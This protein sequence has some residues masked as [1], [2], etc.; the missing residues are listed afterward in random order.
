M[1]AKASFKGVFAIF[2]FVLLL[3]VASALTLSSPETLSQ[4][5]TSTTITATSN[6]AYNQTVSI[7]TPLRITD[8]TY[9]FD[10]SVVPTTFV[11]NGGSSGNTKDITL[12]TGTIPSSFKFGKWSTNL[13]A[14]GT[15][16]TGF[17][18]NNSVQVSFVKGFCSSGA[19]GTN[20][21]IRSVD[22]ENDGEGDE[23]SWNLLDQISVEVRVENNGEDRIRDVIVELGLFD[24]TGKNVIDD[25][26]F[27][28][29]DDEK[30][31]I[32]SLSDGDDEKVLFEFKVPADMETKDYRL[33]AKVYSDDI[34]QSKECDDSASSGLSDDYYETVSVETS[35]DQIIAF[36][37]ITFSP[38]EATCGDAV[39]V[40]FDVYNVGDDDEDQ[41]RVNLV[42]KELGIDLSQEIR[43]GLDAG[44]GKEL[45]FTFT[46]P[47][48]AANKNYN[49]KFDADY[50]YND[51]SD[52]YR[53]SM[54]NPE[55]FAYKVFGCSVNGGSS[56]SNT[57]RIASISA[58]L[59]SDAQAGK[60]LVIRSTIRNTGSSSA[61]FIAGASGYE[62]WAD[63][64]SINPRTFTIGAGESKDVTFTFDVSSETEGDQTFTIEVQSGDKV[65]SRDV[66]VNITSG[67]AFALSL[68]DNWL[69]WV[70][71]IVNVLLIIVIIIVAVRVSR[72]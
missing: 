48:N 53:E 45:S 42:N 10:L 8:G 58:T 43:S 28:S 6:E 16:D 40:N 11:L 37:D 13:Y 60:E 44:E 71:G 32:G 54:E 2:A 65:E 18:V 69:I 55:E 12:S 4:A 26:D 30:V 20:L 21:S 7:Q 23:N 50:D 15:N 51:N 14:I 3:G 29:T 31:N 24:S 63:I 5:R 72:R 56:S 33:A 67:S 19:I 36:D 64:Q 35:D 25:V 39:T 66:S 57:T 49:L 62:S 70:I 61:T 22:I 38:S 9:S 27:I 41:I 52:F 17:T 68:G 59:E 46:V 34:G 47:Q 1:K